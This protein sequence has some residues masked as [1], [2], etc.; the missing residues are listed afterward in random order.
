MPNQIEIL[1]DRA[2]IIARALT[3]VVDAYEDAIAHHGQFA[4]AVAG[5]STPR[6]LYEVLA[7][8]PLDWKKVHVFWGDE[9]YVPVSDPQ[10]NE[11]MTRKV[12]LNL[13]PIP[14]EN[15]HPMPTDELDPAVAAQK[16]DR[17]LQEFFGIEPGVFPKFDL[18]LLG[19]GDDGHT[20][21][22]FPGTAALN[23]SDRLIT[24]GQKDSQ[25]R[26][27]FTAR[28]INQ[29]EKI[30]F[31]VEGAAKANAI[32]AIMAE[33]GDSSKYPARL[34]RGNVTW[35]LDRA[36]ARGVAPE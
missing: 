24:L 11:G 9:R 18:I 12:W 33:S 13:V 25:P 34:I 10:S 2:A 6:P 28:L 5:G 15:I 14:P 35:L 3:L 31:L 19:I 17:H 8:Q 22:L 36:A 23:V 26:L 30:V 29:A 1:T 27:T 7:G 20:A 32:G 4:I 21:S 16:Y